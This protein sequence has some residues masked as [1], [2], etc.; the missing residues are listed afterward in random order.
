MDNLNGF[1]S[2]L[3][4]VHYVYPVDDVE[5]GGFS[6]GIQ[7]KSAKCFMGLA[8]WKNII[9]CDGLRLLK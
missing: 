4:T 7:E 5:P 6:S 9:V 1:G 8:G 2:I 3:P